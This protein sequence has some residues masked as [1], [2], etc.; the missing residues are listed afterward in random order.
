MVVPL[1]RFP[2]SAAVLVV[3]PTVV[4]APPWIPAVVT[5]PWAEV[6]VL[7][8]VTLQPANTIPMTATTTRATAKRMIVER[9]SFLMSILQKPT[10]TL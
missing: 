3:S 8:T 9:V 4:R 10:E 1:V 6:L 5:D 2:L 7:P